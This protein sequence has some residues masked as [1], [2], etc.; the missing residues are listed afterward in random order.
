MLPA[1]LRILSL[2]GLIWTVLQS[3]YWFLE[4]RIVDHWFAD[5]TDFLS[6][7]ISIIL[8]VLIRSLR[9]V[10]CLI[11]VHTFF[12]LIVG[13]GQLFFLLIITGV[14]PLWAARLLFDWFLQFQFLLYREER[15][16]FN[17]ET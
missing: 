4:L 12:L 11:E 17:Y 8:S 10:I 9:Y 16:F 15:K 5:E 2:E 3:Y 14:A 1:F 7:F 13:Y 6:E